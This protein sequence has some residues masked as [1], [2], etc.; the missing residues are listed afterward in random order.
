MAGR[1]IKTATFPIREE[2]RCAGQVPLRLNNAR[3]HGLDIVIALC[4]RIDHSRGSIPRCLA[5]RVRKS[6]RVELEERKQSRGL[7]G[8][9]SVRLRRQNGEREQ[10][11]TERHALAAVCCC[12][13]K[14]TRKGN[15]HNASSMPVRPFEGLTPALATRRTSSLQRAACDA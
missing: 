13:R 1:R 10:A 12:G 8:R 4:E 2:D 11:Q 9:Q 15:N 14:L 3:R 7:F 5:W 6:A